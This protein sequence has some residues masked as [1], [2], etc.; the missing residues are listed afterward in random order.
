MLVIGPLLV[1]GFVFF[2]SQFVIANIAATFYLIVLTAIICIYVVKNYKLILLKLGY[3]P[4]YQ[5]ITSPPNATHKMHVVLLITF[6]IRS[7]LF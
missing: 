2:F 7:S 4:V 3:Y 6:K 1:C 5:P